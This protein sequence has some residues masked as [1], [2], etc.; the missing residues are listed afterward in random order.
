MTG[1]FISV[2]YVFVIGAIGGIFA[3]QIL[4]PYFIERPLFYQYKLEQSPVYVT[5][6]K[7]VTIKENQAL[8]EAVEKVKKV[9]V[10]VYPQGSGIIVT[11]DGLLVTLNDLLPQGSKFYFLVG[12]SRPAYQ[13]LKRDVKNNLA[14][15]KVEE[16]RLSTAGFASFDSL[17]AGE[18]VFLVGSLFEEQSVNEGIIASI[19][20]DFVKT[21]IFDEAKLAGSP[22]FDIEG[23]LVGLSEIDESGRVKAVPVNKIKEFIGF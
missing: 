4:W 15:V 9:V 8:E 18:R 22:L 2:V 23:N 17:K 7:Q 5:E 21:N 13:V 16:D 12:A 19:D 14:L 11:S 20:K 6:R 1:K 10:G 3:D